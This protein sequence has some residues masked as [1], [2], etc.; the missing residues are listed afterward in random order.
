MLSDHLEVPISLLAFEQQFY[1]IS[2]EYHVPSSS[3]GL[4]KPARKKGPS[5]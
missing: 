1:F 5:Q 2:N 4:E 3:R